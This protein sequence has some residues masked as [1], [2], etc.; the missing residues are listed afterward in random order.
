M[1]TEGAQR[2]MKIIELLSKRNT[3][4]S[5][6]DLAKQLGV[7]RQVIVQDLSLIHI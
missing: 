1:L 5:G 2:R 3:P 4:V 7:S 6:T